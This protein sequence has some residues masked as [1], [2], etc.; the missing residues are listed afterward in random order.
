[1]LWEYWVSLYKGGCQLQNK[2]SLSI[3]DSAPL[4]IGKAVFQPQVFCL[5]QSQQNH[6]SLKVDNHSCDDTSHTQNAQPIIHVNINNIL[7]KQE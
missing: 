2:I 7:N 3:Y 4:L 1:M 6:G 5:G